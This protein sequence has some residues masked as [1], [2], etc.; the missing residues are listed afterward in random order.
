MPLFRD[1]RRGGRGAPG[2]ATQVESIVEPLAT[3]SQRSRARLSPWNNWPMLPSS[4][5]GQRWDILRHS[6]DIAVLASENH[7][8]VRAMRSAPVRR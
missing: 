2:V 6:R 4:S 1:G 5:P 3:L 7:G 8:L